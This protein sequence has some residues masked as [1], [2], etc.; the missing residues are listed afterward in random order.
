MPTWNNCGCSTIYTDAWGRV[1]NGPNS[2]ADGSSVATSGCS[3]NWG[4][5]ALAGFAA[6]AGYVAARGGKL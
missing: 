3:N 6:L 1:I 4:L 5:F 2:G